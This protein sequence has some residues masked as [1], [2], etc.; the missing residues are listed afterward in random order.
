[1]NVW[2]T[3]HCYISVTQ[4]FEGSLEKNVYWVYICR[5]IDIGSVIIGPALILTQRLIDDQ[6]ETKSLKPGNQSNDLN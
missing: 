4:V 2:E 1:M 6:T 3:L 5:D